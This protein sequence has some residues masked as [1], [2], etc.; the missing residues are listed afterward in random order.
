MTTKP[1]SV[2]LIAEARADFQ[3]LDKGRKL[4]VAKLLKQL[5]S[6]P[7]KG[8]HLG[9]KAGINLTGYYKLYADKKKIRIVYTVIEKEIVV[10]VIAIGPRKEM[11]VYREAILR[12]G[13]EK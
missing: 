5:E 13:K 10:K 4:K 8:E 3:R 1:F 2:L 12:L 9:N 11:I 6:N 7:Y